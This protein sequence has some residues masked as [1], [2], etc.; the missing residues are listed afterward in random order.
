MKQFQIIIPYLTK[1]L[2]VNTEQAANYYGVDYEAVKSV[3]KRNKDE[4]ESDGV[5]VLKT[6]NFNLLYL[7]LKKLNKQQYYEYIEWIKR[8]YNL[9]T[10]NLNSDLE[11]IIINRYKTLFDTNKE[12]IRKLPSMISL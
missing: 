3:L 4:F 8:K 11:Q 7:V 10:I 1:D 2:V 12:I 5:L 6:K 9:E